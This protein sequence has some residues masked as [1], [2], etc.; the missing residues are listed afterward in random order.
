MKTVLITGANGLIG[1]ILRERLG[2]C[3]AFR[4]LTRRAVDFPTYVGDIADLESILPAFAGVDAVVHMAGDPS[5]GATWESVYR[6]N[7]LGTRNVYEAARLNGVGAVIFA[8]TNHTQAM[9]EVDQGPSVYEASDSRLLHPD[10]PFRPDSFYGFSKASGE[11]LGR[12]YHDAFGLRVFC[13]RIGWVMRDDDPS[14]VDVSGEVVPPIPSEAIR[15]RG[16]AIYLSHRDCAELIRCC[17]EADHI[18]YGV[19]YG[20]SNNAG[21]FYD[22][23]NAR[24]DLGYVPRDGVATVDSAAR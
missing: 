2:D 17:L 16:R 24:E 4:G 14:T 22:M 19:Y 11:T 1:T 8:S 12:Y 18:G 10:D 3:Y 23:T 7:I 15:D 13:L 6:T 21:A 9:W 20:I 5:P